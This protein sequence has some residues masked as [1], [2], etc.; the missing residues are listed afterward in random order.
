MWW[1]EPKNVPICLLN[2]LRTVELVISRSCPHDHEVALIKY[3]LKNANKLEKM[4]IR[5]PSLD[6]GERYT[7]LRKILTFPRGS[8]SCEVAFS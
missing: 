3:M 8:R 6:S 5:T 4:T 7:M 1:T 2:C